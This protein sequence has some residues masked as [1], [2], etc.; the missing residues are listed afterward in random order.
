ME[1]TEE[2]GASEEKI[3]SGWNLAFNTELPI[4]HCLSDYPERVERFAETMKALTSA[5]GYHVRHL[6][7][8]YPWGQLGHGTV[9]DVSI[10]VHTLRF[11]PG[12]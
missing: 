2:F 3:H 9:V 5:D 10:S 4:F 7:D 8:G 1:P 6:V 11:G 12:C